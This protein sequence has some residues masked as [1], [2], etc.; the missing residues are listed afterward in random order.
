MRMSMRRR[1]AAR[2]FSLLEALVALTIASIAFVALYRTVGQTA[3]NAVAL[4]ERTE[5][6]LLARSILA[7]AIYADDLLQ[8]PSGSSGPWQWTVQVVPEQITMD[9][10]GAR[11]APVTLRAGRISLAIARAGRPILS[12]VGWKPYREAP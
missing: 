6:S 3:S 2:G 7:S 10:T 11:Q 12:Q 4:D 1:R 8:H 9:E 5:A